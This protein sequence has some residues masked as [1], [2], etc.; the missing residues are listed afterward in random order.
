MCSFVYK[1]EHW[2]C[3]YSTKSKFSFQSS[4]IAMLLSM[5]STANGRKYGFVTIATI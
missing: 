1:E 5:L 3:K 2:E 4:H